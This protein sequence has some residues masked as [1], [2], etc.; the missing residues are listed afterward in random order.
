MRKIGRLAVC[1]ATSLVFAVPALA[2]DPQLNV[3]NWADYIGKTTIADFE[4]QTGINVVY[5]TYDSDAG[6]EAK[7][8]AGDS[9]YDLVTTAT[10]FFARQIKAGVYETLDKSKLPNWKNL[11]PAILAVIAR[12]D[13]GNAHTVPYLH[14][15]N[16]FAYNV[17]MIKA[18]MPNAPVDSLD[19]VF[20]P[21]IISKFADCGVSFMDNA[22]DVLQLALNYLHLNPNTENPQDFKAAEKLLLAVRPYIRTF[23]SEG[24]MNALPNKDLC[25]ALSW[26]GDFETAEAR[27]KAAG[28]NINLAFTVPKEGA[29]I[30][31]DAWLIPNGA[32][33]PE[34]AY[35]FLNYMLDPRVIAATTNDIHYGNNNAAANAYVAP[36]ILHDPAIYPDATVASRL[37]QSYEV[38]PT[39]ERL[40]TRSWTRIKTGE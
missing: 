34:A 6:L 5:D 17:D 7:V 14:G 29:N 19:M 33:H 37:Y 13:P 20:K 32:P 2:E 36:S 39:V 25:I 4:K 40:R 35:K 9:G 1:G 31:Y 10:D 16:G 8:M 30:W 18:R 23:D 24:F 15:V 38:S 21:E 11:D 3:Y 26:S 12:F 27:A 22:E 28:V